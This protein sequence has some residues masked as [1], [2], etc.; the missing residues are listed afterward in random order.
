MVAALPA[1]V[2]KPAAK[3]VQEVAE[4]PEVQGFALR[5]EALLSAH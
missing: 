3:L 2:D 5:Q 4:P 1:L